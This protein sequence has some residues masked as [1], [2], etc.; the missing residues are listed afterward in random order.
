MGATV[1]VPDGLWVGSG[2]GA[3]VATHLV[4]SFG[5]MTKPSLHSH[6]Y[7]ATAVRGSVPDALYDPYEESSTSGS[8]ASTSIVLLKDTQMVVAGSQSLVVCESQALGVGWCVGVRVGVMVGSLEGARLG[9]KVGCI[10]GWVV[11]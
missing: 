5:L 11:G 2:E 8:A 7:S 6:T 9:V 1:G 10:D 3:T 4:Q